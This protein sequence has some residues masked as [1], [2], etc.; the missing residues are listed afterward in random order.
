[1]ANDI[2]INLFNKL[3]V[4]H[5]NRI[6]GYDTAVKALQEGD[7][8]DL[9]PVFIATSQKCK[10]ELISVVQKLGGTPDDSIKT[11]GELS[12]LWANVKAMIAT[13][14]RQ[15]LLIACEKGENL[16]IDAY[17]EALAT[18]PELIDAPQRILLNAQRAAVQDDLDKVVALRRTVLSREKQ[19]A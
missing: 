15:A 3:I 17:D 8:K 19:L 1:M 12:Q 2:L 11:K 5:N 4:V 9:F 18:H 10:T 14:D 16:T 6:E 13:N 7:L